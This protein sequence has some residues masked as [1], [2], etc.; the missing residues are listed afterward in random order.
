MKTQM[1]AQG[2]ETFTCKR[3]V[4]AISYLSSLVVVWVGSFTP[5][6]T[7]QTVYT[8]YNHSLDFSPFYSYACGQQSNPDQI[9]SPFL[10]Q[11]AQNQSNSQPQGKGLKLVLESQ[12]PDLIVI[13]PGAHVNRPPTTSGEPAAGTVMEEGSITPN[14]SLVSTLVVDLYD[15]KNK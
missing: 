4:S 11:E 3:R 1:A 10:A 2:E 6:A 7:A 8:D 12:S 5:L 15:A 9:T 14:T 13:K